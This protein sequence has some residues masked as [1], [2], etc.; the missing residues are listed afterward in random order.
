MKG[1][2]LYLRILV[3]CLLIKS[4]Y[5]DEGMWLLTML[6]KKYEDLRRAGLKLSPKDIY[7][8]NN[9]SIKDAIVQFGRGCTGGII[10]NNGLLITNHHCGEFAIQYH[11]SVERDYLTEGFWAKSYEEELPVPNLTVSILVKIEDVTKEALKGVTDDMS[12]KERI[13]KIKENCQKI[14]AEAVKGTHYVANVKDFFGGNQYL[15]IVSEVFKDVRLVGAPPASIGNFGGDTDNWMWPR[16]TGDFSLFRI[17]ANKENK[18]ATFSKENIP[19]KPKHV[20]PISLKGIKNN[21]FVMILGYPGKT[22]RYITS[23]GVKLALNTVNPAIIKIRTKKLEVY[24]KYMEKDKKTEIQYSTK[25]AR[26]SNYWKYFIGQNIQL[27]KRNVYQKKLNL[28]SEFNRWVNSSEERKT[29]YGNVLNLFATAYFKLEKYYFYHTYATEAGIRGIDILNFALNFSELYNQLKSDTIPKQ[30]INQLIETLKKQ[31]NDYYKNFNANVDKEVLAELLFIFANDIPNEILPSEIQKIKKKFKN[32][33]YKYANISFNKSIFSDEK[34]VIEFL[35]NPKFNILDNDPI[36][37]LA[38]NIQ[39]SIKKI[40]TE[41]EEYIYML[42]KAERL[43]IAGLM[44]MMP[45]KLFYP[46]ANSTMRLT[47]GHILSYQPADAIFYD[48]YTT[49]DGIIE[50][51]DSTNNEF[52]V[53]KKL[54]ELYEKKDF[55]RYGNEEGKLITCFISNTDIT[56]GNSGSPVLNANG[57]IIGLAFDG[58]WEAMSGDIFFEPALQRTISVDIRYVLFVIDKFANAHNLINEMIIIQ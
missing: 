31:T 26:T 50:K 4:L 10:S 49:I 5:S 38:L 3:F 32:N 30:K 33:F 29:K 6:D 58:N 41:H 51:E 25:W 18:P 55:G 45:H 16:H 7:N 57:E 2:T 8:I 36:F 35:N 22:Q 19:Y 47:Y 24:K 21:D 23:W 28:E 46:D 54:K 11:S 44:E 17:Y 43:F 15:L 34:K 20:L 14:E 39:E 48:Y 53:P 12:E 27:K 1:L 40:Y 42:K 52:I 37:K 56:G 9:S 13:K